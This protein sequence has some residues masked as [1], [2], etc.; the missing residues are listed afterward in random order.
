MVLAELALVGA[1]VHFRP[2]VPAVVTGEPVTVKSEAG[3]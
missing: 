3:R 2:S 1:T